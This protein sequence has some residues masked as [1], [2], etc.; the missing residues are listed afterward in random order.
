[1][2]DMKLQARLAMML[3]VGASV[4][5]A[6]AVDGPPVEIEAPYDDGGTDPGGSGGFDSGGGS[7]GSSD[8]PGSTGSGTMEPPECP[9]QG[10]P[11]IDPTT[12]DPCPS[13]TAGGAH[14]LPKGLVP[15][16]FQGQLDDCDADNM[17]VPDYFIETAGQFIPPTCSSVA[18]S[19]GRCLHVCIPEVAAQADLLP[20]DI[21]AD[22]EVCAPCYDPTTGD[23]TG[24][25]ELSCDPG[26]V[27][28]PTTLPKCCGGQGTCVPPAAAGDQADKLGEDECP[29]DGGALLCA[30]DVFVNDPNWSPPPCETGLIGDL[31]GSQFK[32][33][34]CLPECLP[35]VDNFLIGQD[36]CPDGFKCAPCK[37]PPFGG[38][39]G[40]CDL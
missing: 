14:C 32:P 1:M 16:D 22:H 38:D 5:L 15:A 28:G 7:T 33:G 2:V 11:P 27:E 26:P 31:F 40:A 9:H 21:C 10:P 19:E 12:L 36:G 8:G 29:Q 6:C 39:S 18:G 34:A 30:P 37:E 17:C 24:S 25:C 13:C 3:A 4:P 23:P 35:D 20:Q